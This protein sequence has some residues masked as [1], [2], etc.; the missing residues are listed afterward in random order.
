VDPKS[1]GLAYIDYRFSDLASCGDIVKERHGIWRLA[2]PTPSTPKEL[3]QPPSDFEE[4]PPRIESRVSRIIRDT[5]AARALKTLYEFRCQICSMRIESSFG[6]FY[7]EVHH[8]R[9]LGG[10]HK[11]PDAINN[12]LVLCPNHHAMFDFGIPRFL[13]TDQVEI[14]GVSHALTMKHKLDESAVAYHNNS[15][16]NKRC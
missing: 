3:V 14:A 2:A 13:S 16:R 8:V 10:N 7:I 12:M 9:P 11:G 5:Q 1:N 15:I 4:P 6:D